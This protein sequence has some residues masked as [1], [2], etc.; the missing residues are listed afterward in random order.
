[1]SRSAGQAP[2]GQQYSSTRIKALGMS[3]PFSKKT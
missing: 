1:M 2:M 3:G